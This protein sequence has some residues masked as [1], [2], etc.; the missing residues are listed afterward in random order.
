MLSL[1]PQLEVQALR[2]Q[3]FSKKVGMGYI[4]GQVL[5]KRT[6]STNSIS[7]INQMS[8]FAEGIEL[9]KYLLKDDKLC[10]T[11]NRRFYLNRL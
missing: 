9:M 8:H 5:K 7:V 10:V 1:P 11:N 6:S 3:A 4:S 2:T